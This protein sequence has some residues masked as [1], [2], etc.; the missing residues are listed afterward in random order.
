LIRFGLQEAAKA[1]E[2][3]AIVLGE[4]GYYRR[5]GFRS[6]LAAALQS[7]YAGEYFMALE[8]SPGGLESVTGEVRYAAPFERLK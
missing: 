2:R 5:F 6:E 8:L 7:P 3:V 1:G 4:P